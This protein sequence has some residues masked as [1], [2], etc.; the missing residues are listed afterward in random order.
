MDRKQQV[1][2]E[3][4]ALINPQLSGQNCGSTL[5]WT[6]ERDGFQRLARNAPLPRLRDVQDMQFCGQNGC[7]LYSLHDIAGNYIIIVSNFCQE[8]SFA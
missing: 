3:N 8:S 5:S 1:P 7:D 2:I 4:R 6:F